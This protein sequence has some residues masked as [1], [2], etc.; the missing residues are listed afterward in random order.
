MMVVRTRI[1]ERKLIERFGDDYR[2][3]VERTGA[4]FPRL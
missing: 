2:R 1:E 4:F 3:Y